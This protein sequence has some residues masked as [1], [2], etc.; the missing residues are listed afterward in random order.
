MPACHGK[1][2]G[3]RAV[4]FAMLI[5]ALASS[6]MQ[7][8]PGL[9]ALCQWADLEDCLDIIEVSACVGAV[10]GQAAGAGNIKAGVMYQPPAPPASPAAAPQAPVMP[11]AFSQPPKASP[12]QSLLTGALCT[13]AN[14]GASLAMPYTVRH[15]KIVQRMQA[16]AALELAPFRLGWRQQ[17]RQSRKSMAH[18]RPSRCVCM[19]NLYRVLAALVMS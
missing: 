13:G 19:S 12:L 11:P 5:V 16:Q 3:R 2:E 4:S 9:P 15:A 10:H 1:S 6:I 14:S 17:R 8:L 18:Q 7:G